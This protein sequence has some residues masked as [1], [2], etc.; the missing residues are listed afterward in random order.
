MVVNASIGP[1]PTPDVAVEI[2]HLSGGAPRSARSAAR[3]PARSKAAIC[4]CVRARAR[5]WRRAERRQVVDLGGGQRGDVAGRQR[6]IWRRRRRRTRWRPP[7][8]AVVS[9]ATCA[10]VAPAP[11]R[12]QAG[13]VVRS[14]AMSSVGI[15]G[16]GRSWSAMW[17][18]SARNWS[19]E[20]DDRSVEGAQVGGR[21]R[22]QLVAGGRRPAWS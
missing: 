11:A 16:A 10:V 18:E 6:A 22:R 19:V 12:R 17:S 5:W 4:V 20:R 3:W 8:S 14:G 21:E 1:S 9:T 2:T 13:Q 7:T 15:A